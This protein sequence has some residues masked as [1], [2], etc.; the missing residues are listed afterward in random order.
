MCF[1][2]SISIEPGLR[3][4]DHID[5]ETSPA[6]SRVIGGRS[7]WRNF[8]TTDSIGV[9]LDKEGPGKESKRFMFK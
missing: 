2:I 4:G 8:S 1:A 5:K 3:L 6:T 7:F 9:V